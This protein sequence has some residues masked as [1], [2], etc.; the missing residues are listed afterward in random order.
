V[1]PS[2]TSRSARITLANLRDWLQGVRFP[3]SEARQRPTDVAVVSALRAQGDLWRAVL[4]GDTVA[5][6]L[7]ERLD[8][9]VPRSGSVSLG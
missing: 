9:N 5:E 7:L 8:T 3:S 1:L 2:H 6:D 4:A